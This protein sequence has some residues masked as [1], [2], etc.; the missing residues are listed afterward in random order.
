LAEAED[1]IADAAMLGT[2]SDRL[3]SAEDAAN[4]ALAMLR[5]WAKHADANDD[6]E[7]RGR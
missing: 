3:A 1:E 6:G 5:K 4:A 2:V 7:A